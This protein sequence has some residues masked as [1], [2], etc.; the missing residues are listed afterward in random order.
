MKAF[1][2]DHAIDVCTPAARCI[3][4][5][6]ATAVGASPDIRARRLL[7][8]TW[9]QLAPGVYALPSHPGLGRRR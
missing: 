5:A 7:T 4:P 2:V 6:Q 9:L 3:L 1:A 8:G